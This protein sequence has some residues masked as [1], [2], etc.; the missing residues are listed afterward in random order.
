[1]NSAYL[2]RF[3]TAA[4][5]AAAMFAA[6]CA[7][8]DKPPAPA[9]DAGSQP[10]QVS[11]L[12]S[13]SSTPIDPLHVDAVPKPGEGMLHE[14][15][16]VSAGPRTFDAD[17]GISR[18]VGTERNPGTVRLLNN[19]AAK[20]G[21]FCAVILDRTYARLAIAEKSE[22]ISRTKLPTELKAVVVTAIMSK[23]G[24]L[25]EIILE[26][27]SG[28][29]RIDNLLIDACKKSIWYENPPADA[30]SDDGTYK[31]TIRLK[32]ENFASVDSTH[33]SFT[34]DLG[35]GLG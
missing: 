9:P 31:L 26:Q 34:T 21:N 29:T 24:K 23:N 14:D 11:D 20:Y 35:M 4:M 28:K 2:K 16:G 13:L 33:W 7:T 15:V 30:L 3:L 5:L 18:E 6:G 10:K 32:L 25:T 17:P 22:E 1:M 27:H 12:S 19:K 8:D